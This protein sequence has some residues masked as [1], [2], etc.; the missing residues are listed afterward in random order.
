MQVEFESACA[1]IKQLKRPVSDQD[2]LLIYSY[3]K[4]ATQGDC[5]IAAPPDSDAKA[6]AKWEAWNQNKGMSKMDAMRI[7]IDKVEELKKNEAG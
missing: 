7:Y 5:N 2:K 3:Y 1:A 6:K 4:Q